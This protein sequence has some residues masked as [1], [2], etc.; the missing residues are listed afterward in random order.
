MRVNQLQ[1][2]AVLICVL[3]A[4]SVLVFTVKPTSAQVKSYFASVKPNVSTVYLNVGQT[5][6]ISFEALES[7][8]DSSGQAIE[9]GNV[10]VE[11][12]TAAGTITDMIVANTTTTGFASF[13]YSSPAPQ[14]LTFTPTHLV[15]S[16][17]V[18]LNASLISKADVYG[19]QAESVTVYW[20]TF[21][22]ALVGNSTGTFEAVEVSVNVTYLLLPEEGLTVQSTDSSQAFFPKIAHD[23]TVTVNGVHAEETAV[24][25]VYSANVSTLM[26]TAYMLVE[27][28][29]EGWA[30]AHKAFSFTHD[31]NMTLWAPLAAVF[32]AAFI[33]AL[34]AV[35][36]ALRRSKSPVSR[37]SYLPVFAGFLL[38]PASFIGLY[39]VVVWFESTSHGFD[40]T[41]YWVLGVPSFVFGLSGG[42][43]A[44]C[45][46]KQA[47]V[48]FA[49][50][51]SIFATVAVKASLDAYQLATPWTLLLA[52]LAFSTISGLSI[53]SSDNQFKG[54]KSSSTRKTALEQTITEASNHMFLKLNLFRVNCAEHRSFVYYSASSCYCYCFIVDALLVS[55]TSLP[56][57]CFFVLANSLRRC[58]HTEVCSANPNHWRSDKLF[59]GTQ[60]RLRLL[61]WSSNDVL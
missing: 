9:N 51:V 55:E 18:D 13:N 12:E 47:A 29:Q 48:L 25:G 49:T 43:M 59:W 46:Q 44:V 39:W 34:V 22:V 56:R 16:V 30:T 1:I 17:G 58:H 4:G 24:A 32:A 54:N 61:L 20:D 11:V 53:A 60:R 23:V 52:T 7:Y 5:C 10:T 36:F 42:I 38:M 15:T 35:L 26:P 57:I 27:V 2:T 19:L 33:V 41:L 3:L 8:G 37:R 45:R 50:S 14:I 6:D 31:A 40:W 21:D 28:S